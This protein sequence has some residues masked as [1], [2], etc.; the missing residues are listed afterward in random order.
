M[1]VRSPLVC[2]TPVAAEKAAA[3]RVF[4]ICRSAK[5]RFGN[6]F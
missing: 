5:E 1:A 4:V 6:F 2:L 3:D